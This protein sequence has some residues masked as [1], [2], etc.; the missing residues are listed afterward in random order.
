MEFHF[1]HVGEGVSSQLHVF[2]NIFHRYVC[3]RG[4][5]DLVHFRGNNDQLCNRNLLF[6]LR[7]LAP[8]CRCVGGKV[9]LG[10]LC[11]RARYPLPRL[12]P[13]NRGVVV[14]VSANGRFISVA[15]FTFFCFFILGVIICN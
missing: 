8:F 5:R 1:L 6:R 3:R 14:L 7:D 12:G 13:W 15:M 2:A 9:R 11:V 10:V 4:H